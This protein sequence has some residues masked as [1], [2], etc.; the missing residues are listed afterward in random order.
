MLKSTTIRRLYLGRQRHSLDVAARRL[1]AFRFVVRRI[2]R[3]V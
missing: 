1:L 2:M 3:Q